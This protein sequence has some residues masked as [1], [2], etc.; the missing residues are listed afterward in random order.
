MF[1]CLGRPEN[2]N[3]MVADLNASDNCLDV[4]PTQRGFI[5]AQFFTHQLGG[6]LDKLGRDSAFRVCELAFEHD[7]IGFH[8]RKLFGQFEMLLGEARRRP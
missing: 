2:P 8:M 5:G 1:Q 7:D 4:I 3:L 6:A